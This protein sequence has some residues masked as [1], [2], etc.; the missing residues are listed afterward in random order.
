MQNL[1]H[2]IRHIDDFPTKGV[3]FKDI[4]PLMQNPQAMQQSI[5]ALLAPFAGQ[6]ID[7]IAGLE[8][9]GFIFGALA[10]QQLGVSFVPLRKAGKLPFETHSV[11]YQLEYDTATMEIHRDAVRPGQQVLLVDDVLATGGT[12][13]AG[14]ELIEKL[15]ARI[16]GCTFL[17]E[18]AALKGR[19]HLS[20][21]HTHT[22]VKF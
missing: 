5:E 18:I 8:A 2:L 16:V 4:T 20:A 3:G 17:M 7:A 21:H 1:R 14:C 12:A 13:R 9:R 19:Q 22:L 15:N 10:A 11:A 6:A